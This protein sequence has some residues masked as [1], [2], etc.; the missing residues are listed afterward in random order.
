M[1]INSFT[2]TTRSN[3]VQVDSSEEVAIR[4]LNR[5]TV[6]IETAARGLLL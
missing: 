3:T 1:P 4:N 2:G 6:V 5:C